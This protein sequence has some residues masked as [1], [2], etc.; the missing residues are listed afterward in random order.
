MTA[1]QVLASPKAKKFLDAI[2]MG[3]QNT[4]DTYR[5]ALDYFQNYLIATEKQTLESVIDPLLSKKIDVYDLLQ[6]LVYHFVKAKLA[7]R[8]VHGYMAAVKSYLQYFDVDIDTKKFKRK[9]KIPT[10]EEEDE[11]ELEPRDIRQILLSTNNRR[12]KSWLLCLASGAFRALEL[13]AVRNCDLDF[14]VSPTKVHVRKEYA[15]RKRGRD[16]YISDE[17]T[18]F[19]KEWLDWKY[20][21]KGSNYRT[22][23]KSD[24]D[25]VFTTYGKQNVNGKEIRPK[26]LYNR[27]RQDFAKVLTV[28]KLDGK[29]DGMN[30]GKITP[31]S[32]R[33]TV[34][35][36]ISDNYGKD[37]AD[38]FL[39][40]KKTSYHT[41][42]E[43][44][45]RQ[46]YANDCMPHLTYL[47]YTD[48]DNKMKKKTDEVN[49]L[50]EQIRDLTNEVQE[51]KEIGRNSIENTRHTI[52]DTRRL[53]TSTDSFL[54]LIGE[55][56]ENPYFKEWYNKWKETK[57]AKEKKLSDHMNLR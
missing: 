7:T 27:L 47:D 2:A 56:L 46:I 14:S 51:L 5:K 36:Q 16:V 38:G 31:H 50:K 4:S 1:Q 13:C 41:L 44:K 26:G 10:I 43:E 12:L 30:R 9:V 54:P 15:K 32:F 18:R 19:L 53:K 45:R 55:L 42:K 52:E 28:V 20:R 25:L 57:S 34:Y 40:H 33:R 49:Q 8:T 3:S 23:V 22:F 37:Y 24:D 21:K 48:V 11:D 6:G 17:A 29:K 35:T 39:G